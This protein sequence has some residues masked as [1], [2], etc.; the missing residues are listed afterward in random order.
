M[1]RAI[2]SE[3]LESPRGWA[4]VE[5]QVFVGRRTPE[6]RESGMQARD[7]PDL[8]KH[9]ILWLAIPNRGIVGR[10]AIRRRL[11]LS[12][13]CASSSVTR[14]CYCRCKPEALKYPI[15]HS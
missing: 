4:G 9:P 2:G 3:R 7:E 8:P 14:D 12:S 1:A 10:D 5:R 11:A 6:I 13:I 15:A